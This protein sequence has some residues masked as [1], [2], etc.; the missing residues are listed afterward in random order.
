MW[1]GSRGKSEGKAIRKG[2]KEGQRRTIRVNS[3]SSKD[4]NT[5]LG[6]LA[7]DPL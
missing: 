3:C 1:L 5:L 6:A 2:K 7:Q 4:T